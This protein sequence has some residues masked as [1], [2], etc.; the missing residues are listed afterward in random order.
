MFRLSALSLPDLDPAI[1]IINPHRGAY[2]IEMAGT[3]PGHDDA[4][5]LTR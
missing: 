1:P 2:L 4:L 5:I 3:K